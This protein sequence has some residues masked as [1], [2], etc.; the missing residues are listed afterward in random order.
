MADSRALKNFHHWALNSEGSTRGAGLIRIGLVLLIW[1]RYAGL[2]LFYKD[3]SSSGF[4]LSVNFY[5]ATLLMFLGWH[6]RFA[7]A[8]TAVVLGF[9][10]YYFGVHLNHEAWTHHHT[11]LLFIATCFLS[12]SPC[13]RSFSLDRYLQVAKA[14]ERGEAPPQER[15]NLWG[16]KLIALQ[17]S[18]IYFFSAWD[19]CN[20]AFLSGDRMEHYLMWYYLGSD[21]PTWPGFHVLMAA[22]AWATVVLEFALAFGLPF[23]RTRRYV[24]WPGIGLHAL[25]FVLLP[26]RTY[27]ATMVL[28]YLTYLN[29][30]AIHRVTGMILG[31]SQKKG[32]PGGRPQI[33]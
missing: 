16:L 13:G 12:L 25:F 11:Y 5:A 20:W 23:R 6:A 33:T 31:E 24:I 26:V 10:Y 4:L 27:S 28:L 15:G 29:P 2:L 1:S 22:V 9:M 17:L 19:K 21:Y 18:V 3:M 32:L 7:T 30:E 14:Q 8:Y